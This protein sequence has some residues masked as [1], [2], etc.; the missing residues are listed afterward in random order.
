M[1]EAWVYNALLLGCLVTLFVAVL[2]GLIILCARLHATG[3]ISG[4]G[5]VMRPVHRN[6]ANN[7]SAANIP[8]KPLF[9]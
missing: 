2:G 7:K 8:P 4:L 1:T 5:A 9:N 6:A 3:E